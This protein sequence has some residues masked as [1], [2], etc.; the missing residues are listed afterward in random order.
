MIPTLQR[1]SAGL[2]LDVSSKLDWPGRRSN[3]ESDL[4][5]SRPTVYRIHPV[6]MGKRIHVRTKVVVVR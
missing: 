2:H 3:D 5:E 4:L 1:G 6:R